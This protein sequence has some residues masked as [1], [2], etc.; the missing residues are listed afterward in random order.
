MKWVAVIAI[1]G[2]VGVASPASACRWV[3]DHRALIHSALPAV[4]S[5]DAV[6]LDVEIERDDA[7]HLYREGLS[8]RVRRVVSGDFDRERVTIRLEGATSCDHPFDNGAVG[9]IVGFPRPDGSFSPL[10]VQQ[11]NGFQLQAGDS[12][13]GP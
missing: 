4:L 10:L 12:V 5:A 1:A 6:V 13:A 7:D 2:L 3:G 9:M 11:H 8:A